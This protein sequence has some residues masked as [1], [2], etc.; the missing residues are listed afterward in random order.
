MVQGRRLEPED[1]R[2]VWVF[3]G[4]GPQ[5]WGM[6]RGLL[7]SEPVFREVVTACDRE[8]RR[9]AGWSLLDEMA[10]G[11]ETSRMAETWLAQ[12][13]NFA[14]QAGLAALWRSYGVT[15]DAVVGHSTGEIA[16]FH[17]AGVYSLEEAVGIAVHR[18]RLQHTLAGTG[19]MLAVSLSEEEAEH[20]VRPYA[21][22][23]CVAAVNS[24]T[25]V[26]LAGDR[27]TLVRLSGELR[28]EQIF[29]KLLTVQVPY[30]SPQM[31]RIKDELLASLAGLAPRPAQVPVHLTGIEGPADGVVL[32]AAYWW[33]NVRDRVAFRAAVDRLA[34]EGHRLFLEIG[35]HPALAHSLRE[36]LEATGRT[37]V[38]VPSIRRE[39]DE[40]ERFAASLATL[41][42]LGVDID[43]DV[44]QPTG[45]AVPLPRY[46]WRRDRHWTEPRNVAQVRLGHLDHPLLGRRT[47]HPGPAW[48]SALD[49]ERLPYLADHRIQDSVVFPAAGY[50]EMATQAVLALTGGA[51]AVLA[52]V[53]LRKALFLAEDQTTTV[54]LTVDPESADFAIAS[55]PPGPGG[56]RAVHATGTVRTAQHPAAGPPLD[57]AAVQARSGQWLTGSACYT[58]LA[59]LGYHYGPAFQALD[60]VWIGDGEVLARISPPEALGD[61]PARHHLHPVL[62]DAC[63]Q[64]LLTR[65]IPAD[66][67]PAPGTGIRLPLS[68]AELS[69]TPVGDRTLWAHGVITRDDGDELVADLAL[70][71]EDGTPSAASPAS[72]PPTSR[73]PPP[74]SPGPP[75][76]PGWPSPCGPIC[77]CPRTPGRRP[78]P[79]ATGCCSPTAT[80]VVSVPPSPPWSPA[81]ATA[82]AR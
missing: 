71:A 48:Q 62:L 7:E 25:G 70:Y 38:T 43:W 44:L 81:S 52:D 35:P 17:E 40:P 76:T 80:P 49:T 77:R 4:M 1:R 37:A 22:R 79:A 72:A 34:D 59:A 55:A 41:H 69:L 12:P 53:D 51:S 15:P 60:E 68:I 8:I 6:G 75:S 19:G 66:G 31:D 63:F 26:T 67:D 61:D 54:H 64:S 33:R 11:A 78:N 18:S 16:A 73:R 20:R 42:N 57:P 36:C 50:L 32:D 65:Q 5:W 29:A 2:L 27:D 47:D 10:A 56:E 58:G 13:A 74:P 3:T 24:P 82:A 46:P 45:R 28:D 30:H 39:E 23:V 14:V 9:L 21:D